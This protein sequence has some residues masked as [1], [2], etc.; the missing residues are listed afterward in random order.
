MKYGLTLLA[1]CFLAMALETSPEHP[2]KYKIDCDGTSC[3]IYDRN[4]IAFWYGG[5]ECFN[6]A[7]DNKYMRHILQMS[8]YGKCF[9]REL[10]S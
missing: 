3:K 9:V 7:Q 8:A 1:L 5:D 6:L 10:D 4:K 2:S